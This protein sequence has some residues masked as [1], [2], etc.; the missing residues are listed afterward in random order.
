MHH[1]IPLLGESYLLSRDLDGAKRLA[2][3]LRRD[4]TR[5]DHFIG[6]AWADACDALVTWLSGDV[7]EGTDK[8]RDAADRLE[9]IPMSYDAARVRRQY[10]GRL[11]ELGRTD[12]ALTE[13]RRAHAVFRDLG[14][15]PELEKSRGMFKELETR[16]PPKTISRGLGGLTGRE[17]D[18]ARLVA[19]NKAI[20]KELGISPR[21]VTTHLTNIYKKL[22]VDSRGG[23]VDL[24]R[25]R[26]WAAED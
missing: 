6:L 5:M 22:E 9:A 3:R 8:L 10:A 23:L 11:A 24:V 2:S 20:G 13:L 19:S 16:P 26:G 18:I 15:E 25:E 1:L 12:E 21:T 14:A 17:F 7:E 4:A